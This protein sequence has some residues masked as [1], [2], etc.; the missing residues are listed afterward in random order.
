[1]KKELE[2]KEI[3]VTDHE[4]TVYFLNAKTREIIDSM[5]CE[6]NIR[7]ADGEIVDSIDCG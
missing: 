4:G 1:M 5:D 6:G 3:S 7:N 2:E